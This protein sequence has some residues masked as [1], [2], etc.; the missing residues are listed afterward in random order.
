M[1]S[2]LEQSIFNIIDNYLLFFI[3]KENVTG[4]AYGHKY[5]KG[6]DT[7]TPCLIVY[8]KK[9]LPKNKL[10]KHNL[11]PSN[12]LGI[13]TDVVENVKFKIST[14]T[15]PKTKQGFYPRLLFRKRPLTGGYSIG[16]IKSKSSGTLGGIVFDNRDETPYI[17]SNNHVLSD[18]SRFPLGSYILQPSAGILGA[19]TFNS[20]ARLSKVVNLNYIG[21]NAL[22]KISSKNPVQKK[23][24]NIMDVAL[25]EVKPKVSYSKEVFRVGAINGTSSVK[26][27]DR[28]Q[29]VGA[30]SGY[31]RGT[32]LSLHF[33]V[34]M[35]MRYGN[36][37]FIN[38]INTTSM[39]EEGDSGS[40]VLNENNKVIGLLIGG[41]DG[42]SVITPIDVIL[43]V[44]N[45]HF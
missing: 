5:I 31:T 24:S 32:V 1:S 18:E 12:F 39:S 45:V 26:V 9:K 38:Q 22:K 11:I 37:I 14:S 4:I 17:L 40:L 2:L 13:T 44:L 27:G 41:S 29:K 34:V 10:T 43:K 8:V 6:L 30:F 23:Y 20:V 21:D 7:K 42:T 33:T 36:S 25:A 15:P 35:D 28:I 3:S 19:F 16:N